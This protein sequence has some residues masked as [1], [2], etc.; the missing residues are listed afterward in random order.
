MRR[1]PYRNN[2]LGKIND[3][4][5]ESISAAEERLNG[6]RRAAINIRRN[7]LMAQGV[8]PVQAWDQAE[9]EYDAKPTYR[10]T[11]AQAVQDGDPDNGDWARDLS[12]EEAQL[13][14]RSAQDWYSDAR[15]ARMVR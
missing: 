1:R 6:P 2:T 4:L 13:I 15:I 10:I 5:N 3:Q 8:P 9:A 7:E 12:L 11:S 14:L